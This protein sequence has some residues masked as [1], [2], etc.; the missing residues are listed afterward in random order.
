MRFRFT[1]RDLLWLFV[2]IA[3][4][5]ALRINR[6]AIPQWEYTTDVIKDSSDP[7]LQKLGTEGW[8]VCTDTPIGDFHNLLLKRQKR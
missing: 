4:V 7:K 3:L 2:V 8:E 1:I 6:S 5:L